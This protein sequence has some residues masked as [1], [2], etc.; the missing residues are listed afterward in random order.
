MIITLSQKHIAD[1]VRN[2]CKHCPA[3]LAI[4]EGADVEYASVGP[5]T[6]SFGC[7]QDRIYNSDTP[8]NVRIFMTCFDSGL[9]VEPITF[10]LEQE[11]A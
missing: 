4:K 5:D 8:P 7:L 1:G 6:L 11:K 2:S 10:E 9:P 3:A